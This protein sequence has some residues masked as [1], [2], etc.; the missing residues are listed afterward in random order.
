MLN[1]GAPSTQHN[2]YQQPAAVNQDFGYGGND[3]LGGGA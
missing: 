1:F 2:T 3:L